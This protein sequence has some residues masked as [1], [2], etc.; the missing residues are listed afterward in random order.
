MDM[1]SSRQ[2]KLVMEL[3]Q[4]GAKVKSL[5]GIVCYITFVVDGTKI[6]YLYNINKDNEYFLQRIS[7][8][9][10][11][12]GAFGTEGGIVRFIKDDI[13]KFECTSSH[14]CFQRFIELNLSFQQA[15]DDM[16]NLFIH[17][18]MTEENFELMEDAVR[19]FKNTL[20]LLKK[21]AAEPVETPEDMGQ[22]LV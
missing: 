2:D 9:P 18:D 22:G 3:H 20:L 1:F 14:N 4:L 10:L 17:C 15:L 13:K 7:P 16:E 21:T 11:S 19:N 6:T 5:H 8:Y 12:V